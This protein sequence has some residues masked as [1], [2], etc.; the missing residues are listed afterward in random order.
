MTGSVMDYI[1]FNI[2]EKGQKQGEYSQ[3]TLGPYDYW[4][5]EYAYKAVEGD[6]PEAELPQLRKIASRVAEP[7]LA[8]GTD[9]DAGGFGPPNEI[10]PFANRFDLGN[11][12]LQYY[13]H[14]IRLS[15]EVRANIETK[16]EKQ[17]EGYQ[18]MLRSFNSSLRQTGMSLMLASKYIG[19]VEHFRDHVGD[20][21]ARLPY[22]PLSVFKQKEA[23]QLINENAF[24]PRAFQFSP[25]LL[26]KLNI[27]RVPDRFNSNWFEGPR[28][29][30]VHENI[31]ELQ[32]ALL[33]RVF[34]PIV[35]KRVA[36][37]ELRYVNPAER[38]RMSELFSSVQ[39]A[40]WAE[41]QRTSAIE[42]NSVRR[43]LQRAHLN[44]MLNLLLRD[45]AAPED[46]RTMARYSL[47]SLRAQL[48]TAQARAGSVETKAHI[49][50]SIARIDEGLEVEHSADGV[51]T[52][53][54]RRPVRREWAGTR[55]LNSAS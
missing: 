53:L 26:N 8:Y 32:K 4:A 10:D 42:V 15:R 37:N 5:I 25:N 34:N 48:A 24:A 31:L 41:T 47:I 46:A 28:I 39:N 38:L 45:G 3:S 27:E 35:L 13:T 30:Q 6:N 20:A 14:R 12:P 36:D 49:D 50:E 43:G 33:D 19:G 44:K 40:V 21:N 55:A 17:G 9:E 7:L 23:L 18:V 1:P 29:L 51:L 22:R 52:H 16:L 2:S 11:D 54:P